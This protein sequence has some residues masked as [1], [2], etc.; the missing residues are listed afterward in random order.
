MTLPV[1]WAILAVLL[2]VLA[3]LVANLSA[4][5]L[6]YHL[7]VGGEILDGR[8]IPTHDT[9][10]FTAAGEPWLDQQWG[11]Q[12]LLAAVHRLTGW[13]GL[14]VLRAA[15]VGLTFGLVFAA[16]RLKGA[17]L[18]RAAWLAL[19]AFVVAAAALALRPQLFG[20]VLLAACLAVLTGR[21]RW[22]RAIWLI[23]LIAVA[24]AN[25]HGSFFLAPVVAGLA[26]L[27]D[28]HDRRATARTTLIVAVVAAGATFLN[29]YGAAVWGYALGLSTN[30]LITDR[31]TEWQPTTIRTV[32]GVLFY[33][34]ALAV[35]VVLARRAAATS[36]ATLVWLAF[37]FAI[38]AFAIRGVAWWPLA[39]AVAVAG[40]LAR[41]DIDEA[42]RTPA[43]VRRLN[44]A[45]VGALLVA[46]VVLM[47]AWRP[48]EPN[49][50]APLGVLGDAP[51][52]ITAALREL[53]QPGDRIFNPQP[54][55]S[56]LEYALPDRQFAIDSR[57][58]VFPADVW[59][60]HLAVT[61]GSSAWDG[62]LSRWG[63]D[64]IV[65]TTDDQLFIQRLSDSGWRPGY[66][67]ADGVV[68]IK[69]LS[70]S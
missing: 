2:P 18:R 34:S 36:W 45:I 22:P 27:E 14:V 6:A 31:I 15:L 61:S 8:G 19:A 13:T 53:T 11:A 64:A 57:I 32:P 49:L 23:P 26:W 47:P 17:D 58:E 25:L 40:L 29:P 21:H 38:G 3:A 59:A 35:V 44:V 52:G 55:G 54:W 9:W 46:C 24:W 4:V 30:S 20:M 56:W 12:V 48:T 62:L 37:F 60:D 10:T 42:V 41:G 69:E 65:A 5:D 7:R 68:F 1:L 63:V 33:G 39:A 43:M 16:C 50:G 51:P 66:E 28:L 67:D 70:P